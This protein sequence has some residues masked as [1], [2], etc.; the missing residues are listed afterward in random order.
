[1]K[2]SSENPEEVTSPSLIERANEIDAQREI[3]KQKLIDRQKSVDEWNKKIAELVAM[4][5]RTVDNPP[6]EFD[7]KKLEACTFYFEK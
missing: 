4:M 5:E 7:L 1:M 2:T 3:D 6:D